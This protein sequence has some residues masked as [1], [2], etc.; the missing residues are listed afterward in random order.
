MISFIRL[1]LRLLNAV[2]EDAAAAFLFHLIAF[3]R[4][5]VVASCRTTDPETVRRITFDRNG[6]RTAWQWGTDGPLVI[7]VHGWEGC[8]L[9]FAAIG[10]ALAAAGYRCVAPDL[11]A[12]GHSSGR[13]ARFSDFV[14]DVAALQR[15]FD[16]P[17]AAGIG[18]SAGGMVLMAATAET[19][20]SVDRCVIMASPIAPL[21]A[22]EMVQRILDPPDRLILRLQEYL[23]RQFACTWPELTAGA[24]YSC[25]AASR[26]LLVYDDADTMV[27]AEHG[28]RI[29][30]VRPDALSVRTR[31]LGHN[32]ILTD[33]NV[34]RETL[35]FLRR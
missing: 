28:D 19:D 26:M 5:H 24:L 2:S 31:G 4:R 1:V 22:V 14:K 35:R 9:Q 29:Q 3:P 33:P 10:N 8:G 23:G 18:H 16:E 11:T 12:H 30:T 32:R 7:C 15:Q 17:V 34:I 13:R 20:L 21:P 6:P 27:P 25:C